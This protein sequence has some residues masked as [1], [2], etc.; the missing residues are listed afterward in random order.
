MLQRLTSSTT[1]L[2]GEGCREERRVILKAVKHC[3]DKLLEHF[4]CGEGFTEESGE[5]LS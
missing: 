4:K 3:W 2:V 1:F 5:V